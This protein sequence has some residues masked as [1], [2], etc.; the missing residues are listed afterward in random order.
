[1]INKMCYCE[2]I[3]TRKF[4]S[5]LANLILKFIFKKMGTSGGGPCGRLR[6]KEGGREGSKMAKKMRTSLMDGP[7]HFWLFDL[8]IN[9]FLLVLEVV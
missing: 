3:W 6:T 2:F 8:E 1:M 9:L 7:L 4:A 5:Y